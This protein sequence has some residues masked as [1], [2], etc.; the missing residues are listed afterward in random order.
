MHLAKD[1]TDPPGRTTARANRQKP[2]T[3]DLPA[4]EVRRASDAIEPTGAVPGA[5]AH[6][7]A[8]PGETAAPAEPAQPS[9]PSPK[10]ND[11]KREAARPQKTGAE[12][13]I[14]PSAFATSAS[15]KSAEAG[16]SEE[17][18]GM[19]RGSSLPML[20]AASV[21]GA[22]LVGLGLLLL[23]STGILSVANR[24]NPDAELAALRSEI[25]ALRQEASGS[26][27]AP[28]RDQIAALEQ[29]MGELRNAGS[30]SARD[31]ALEEMQ[32]RLS[33]LENLAAAAGS[34]DASP[35]SDARFSELAAEIEALRSLGAGDGSGL[36]ALQEEVAALT[37]RVEAVPSEERIA[38]M[39]ADIQTASEQA[40][41]AASL[42]PAVAADALA[43]ALEAGR[44]FASELGAVAALGLD[45][46]ARAALQ[47]HAESGLATLPELRAGFEAAITNIDFSAP[48]PE[49][50]GAIDRL[51]QSARGLVEVR[52]ARP[53]E[54]ADPAAVVTRIRAALD[55]GDL[56]TALAEW[57][58]LPDN[59]KTR[60]A[61]WAGAAEARAE[62]DA[63][64]A[65]LRTDALSRLSQAG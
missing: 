28:L 12:E 23:L 39:E 53:T 30:G 29:S 31:A 40:A 7:A 58:T 46:A 42:A 47:P 13:P 11:A 45:E 54:G 48:I 62:A 64:V 56:A 63:L 51:L 35:A 6:A 21:A 60:S 49:G 34:P 38:A 19:R 37:E 5:E 36:A 43:A 14:I 10:R 4:E 59:M 9:S 57:N 24:D 32:T 44:P 2:V 50:T 33:E 52:P 15:G 65:R 8:A 1:P 18:G 22:A 16:E 3:I 55:A 27:L 17:P 26:D 25:D 20:V 61:D 41:T